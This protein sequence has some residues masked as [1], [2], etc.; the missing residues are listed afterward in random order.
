MLEKKCSSTA[1]VM[2]DK[3]LVIGG[4]DGVGGL[5]TVELWCDKTK[6]WLLGTKLI[7]RRTGC[8]ACVVNDVPNVENYAW[9]A[10]ENIVQERVN[11]ALGITDPDSNDLQT[12]DD[13]LA[14]IN[15]YLRRPSYL[16][17]A[18]SNF[19]DIM[20]IDPN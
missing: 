17:A 11:N 19:D 3:I 6:R 15:Q 2:D 18:P 9:P 5:R 12:N 7:R 4:W 16:R 20:D 10:R 8:A 14:E 1:V 13:Q